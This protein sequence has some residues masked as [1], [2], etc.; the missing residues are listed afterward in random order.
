M[1]RKKVEKIT[2]EKSEGLLSVEK[3][4]QVKQQVREQTVGYIT[5]AFGLIAGLAWNEAIKSFI[6]TIFVFGNG[7]IWAKFIYASFV[8]VILVLVT[9]YLNHLFKVDNKK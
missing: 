8:T 3:I 2:E 9:I 5:A 6:E 1:P 4:N 7:T